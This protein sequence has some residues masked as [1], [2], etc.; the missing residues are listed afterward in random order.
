[1]ILTKS[2]Y[3]LTIPWM[4]PSSMD[5]PDKYILQIYVW[6][7]L[8][9]SVP[10][11]PLYEEENINP[12]GLIGSLDVNISSYVND[13]LIVTP[14]RGFSTGAISNN[15]SAWVKTQVVYYINGVAQSPEFVNTDLAIRGYGYG[16]E[17]KNTSTPANDILAYG[18]EVNVSTQSNFILPFNRSETEVT[19]ITIKSFPNNNINYSVSLPTTDDSNDLV[20]SAFVSVNEAGTDE[21]IE[22]KR[23]NTLSHTLILKQELRYTPFDCWFV[24][25][26]GQ[27]YSFTFFK[28]K[29]TSLKVKSDSY[30]SS[31]GQ[32]KSG[33]HQLETYNKT[34]NTSFKANSGFISEENNEIIKQL[35][36]SE[37]VWIL[38][39]FLFNPVNVSSSSVSYKSRQ[40]D[41]LLNYEVNFDYAYNEINDI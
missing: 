28:E 35:F 22:I 11:T 37:K 24:N 27:L 32:P 29:E 39:G 8:K 14:Y 19:D 5:V 10:A 21:Y 36:L 4:S 30:E 33:V 6:K 3:Y 40:K 9:T 16:I 7:G 38:E 20:S 1:M 2:P 13:I 25:K 31:I 18:E 15:T 17:G 23:N 34:G 41:R 26:Y 12:L